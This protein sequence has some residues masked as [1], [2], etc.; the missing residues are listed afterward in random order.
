MGTAER[1]ER[2][3]FSL[4]HLSPVTALSDFKVL[5]QLDRTRWICTTVGTAVPVVETSV[6]KASLAARVAFPVGAAEVALT[7]L[8]VAVSAA[9]AM[10]DRAVFV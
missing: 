1:A 5:A 9:V 6:C 10:A 7:A 4:L 2:F 8:W 3:F